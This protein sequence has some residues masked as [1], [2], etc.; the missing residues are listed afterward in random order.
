MEFDRSRGHYP[1]G[2]HSPD[3]VDLTGRTDKGQP[4]KMAFDDVAELQD[5][6]GKSGIYVRK[7]FHAVGSVEN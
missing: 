5:G 2:L 1:Q 3:G 4:V 6:R 7:M